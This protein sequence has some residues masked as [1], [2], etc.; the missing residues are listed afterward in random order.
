MKF[1]ICLLSII[2]CLLSAAHVDAGQNSNAVISLDYVASGQGNRIDD[3]VMSGTV[4]GRGTTIV[5]EVFAKNVSTSLIAVEIL[6]KSSSALTYVGAENPKTFVPVNLSNGVALTFANPL[7]PSANGDVFLA[8]AQFTTLVDVSNSEFKIEIEKVKLVENINNFDEITS[9][10]EIVFNRSSTTNTPNTFQIVWPMDGDINYDGQVNIPDFLLL[11]DNFG[12]TGT[13]PTSRM[14]IENALA[15]GGSGGT[16]ITIR[17]TIYQTR[18]VRDTVYLSGGGT[19]T[20]YVG[21]DVGEGLSRIN[22]SAYRMNWDGSDPDDDG[23]EIRVRFANK[24]NYR[25]YAPEIMKVEVTL[26]KD[27]DRNDK[28][29]VPFLL[30]RVVAVFSETDR[31]TTPYWRIRKQSSWD[32]LMIRIPDEIYSHKLDITTDYSGDRQWGV[33]DVYVTTTSGTFSDRD[34]FTALWKPVVPSD[35]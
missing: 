2:C 20:I 8:K 22:I 13:V 4:S 19:D 11:V 18:T 5:V 6:F 9:S 14:A 7:I 35:E 27:N 16:V 23:I 24:N 34:D 15:T 25:I 26:G 32:D 33:V 31:K 1:R 28:P 10:N 3:G 17:D 12:K 29:D 21:Q 30:D